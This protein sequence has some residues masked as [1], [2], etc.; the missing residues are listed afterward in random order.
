MQHASDD[1]KFE[2]MNLWIVD[3]R[4]AYHRYLASDKTLRSMP[5]VESDSTKEPDIAIF[6]QAFA[7]S[8]SDSHS[9]QLL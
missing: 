6:D 3:E 8:D 2:E 1:V 5:V 4:L 7:Y 9:R